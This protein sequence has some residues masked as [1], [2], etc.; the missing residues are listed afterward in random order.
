MGG[1]EGAISVAS[2]A[3]RGGLGVFDFLIGRYTRERLEFDKATFW[4]SGWYTGG[5]YRGRLKST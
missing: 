3:I 5:L 1:G 4:M 2:R